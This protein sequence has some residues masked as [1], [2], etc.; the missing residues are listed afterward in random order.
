MK[1][2][3]KPIVAGIMSI[4]A[5][6]EDVCPAIVGAIALTLRPGGWQGLWWLV[7]LISILGIVAI[8]GGINAIKR[9]NYHMAIA[10]AICAVISPGMLLGVASII[11]VVLSE[12]EFVPPVQPDLATSD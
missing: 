2:T 8:I 1:K 4:L 9:K 10:G 7:I 12:K 5:G 11:L 6:A 3:W